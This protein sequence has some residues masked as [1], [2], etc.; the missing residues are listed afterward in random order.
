MNNYDDIINYNYTGSKRVKHM[1]LYERS[2]IFSAYQ[3]LEGY[4]DSVKE[5]ERLTSSKKELT[6]EEKE[7]I[8]NKIFNLYINDLEGTFVYFVK[9]NKKKG[10]SYQEIKGKIKKIDE[11]NMNIILT[12]KIILNIN[13]II[14]IK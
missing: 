3:A 2:A 5:T 8:N 6:E 4:M 12:S 13:D 10:G 1:S 11:I 7:I 9:D 14:N